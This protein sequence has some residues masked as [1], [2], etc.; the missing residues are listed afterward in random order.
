MRV[1]PRR[2]LR[3]LVLHDLL[4]G[5]EVGTGFKE[6]RGGRVPQVVEAQRSRM[7]IRPQPHVARWAARLVGRQGF[8]GVAA[9]PLPRSCT[10]ST[11]TPRSRHRSSFA[12]RLRR[13]WQTRALVERHGRARD[14]YDLVHI[15]R[16]FRE[17]SDPDLARSVAQQKFAFKKLPPPTVDG[18]IA[19]I[20]R[21]VL[22]ANWEQQL[23]HQVP[24]LPS[25]DSFLDELRESIARWLEPASAA[26]ALPP[27]PASIGDAVPR[28]FF[29]SR[30]WNERAA[31]LDVIRY[32]ARNRLLVAFTYRGAPR[33]VEPYSIRQPAT[34]SML[35]H[36]WE[37]T[38]N[39]AATTAHY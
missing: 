10:T 18:I 29:P 28:V 3:A 24:S 13:S 27:I 35:L 1:A 23:V 33:V 17:T 31:A 11:T 22:A 38:K 32:A 7:R 2:G 8:A 34:G 14:V 25:V 21:D 9:T 19:G 37:V 12:T 36:A 6:E 5:V 16:N 39:G 4:H 15:A 20:D 30:R 26:P